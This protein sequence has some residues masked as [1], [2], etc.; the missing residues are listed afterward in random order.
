VIAA[1]KM[2]FYWQKRHEED[3]QEENMATSHIHEKK[4]RIDKQGTKEEAGAA[5]STHQM[6]QGT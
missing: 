6:I 5:V 2:P 3:F 4:L 1:K